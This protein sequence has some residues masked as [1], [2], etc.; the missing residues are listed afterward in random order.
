M[1]KSLLVLSL[2]GVIGFS[3]VSCTNNEGGNVTQNIT[4]IKVNVPSYI[5]IGETK[6]ISYE[7]VGDSLN[8]ALFKSSDEEILS[9]SS[10]GKITG[11]KAGT[12]TITVSSKKNPEIKKDVT[13]T[14]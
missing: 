8:E 3:A 6:S 1:K 5:V 7:V 9:V 12:G 2:V 11:K 14:V 10:D 13:I 4:D